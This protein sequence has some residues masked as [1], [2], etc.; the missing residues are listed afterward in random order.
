MRTRAMVEWDEP[1]RPGD[2]QQA[3]SGP[4]REGTAQG[5]SL[6]PL[7]W[8]R[9]YGPNEMGPDQLDVPCTTPG[10]VVDL[11]ASAGTAVTPSVIPTPAITIT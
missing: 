10:Y 7:V 6:C 4:N 1:S 5:T 8:W 9:R 2:G 3:S 11:T